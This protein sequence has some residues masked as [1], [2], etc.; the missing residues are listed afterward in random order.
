MNPS[1]LLFGATSIPGFNLA[2]LFPETILPF[3]PP[4]NKSPSVRHWSVLQLENIDWIKV[5]FKAY[6]PKSMIYCH[7]VCDV[8]K[9]EKD[10]EWAHEMNVAHLKR[11]MDVIP[12]KTR[13]IYVSSDHVFGGDGRYTEISAPSPISVYGRTRAAA[14]EVVLKRENS[15][16]LRIG[17]PIG[18]SANGRTG[19]FDWLAYRCEQGLPI[20]IIKDEYRS[21]VCAKALSIRIM[22]FLESSLTGI[23]HI[24][25]TQ[26]ISRVDLAKYLFAVLGKKPDFKIESRHTQAVPH[27]G[28]VALETIYNGVLSQPLPSIL[29]GFLQG[30][31]I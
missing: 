26:V 28:R 27:L 11:V 16:V 21:V 14:E 17:L 8:T 7:A 25:A 22:H 15:L 3:V 30:F 2:R 19:H 23:R 12:E 24:P 6:R 9:C 1:I 31:R 13:F 18:P 10:P 29:K 20:T 5:Q 4:S